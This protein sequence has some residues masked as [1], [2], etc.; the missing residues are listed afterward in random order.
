MAQ[1]S[2]I[3]TKINGEWKPALIDYTKVSNVWK[4]VNSVWTKIAGEWVNDLRDITFNVTEKK[5][6]EFTS[7]DYGVYILGTDDKLYTKDDWKNVYFDQFVMLRT[8]QTRAPSGEENAA[9]IYVPKDF[10]QSLVTSI[11]TDSYKGQTISFSNPVS[12]SEIWIEEYDGVIQQVISEKT[13]D[14]VSSYYVGSSSFYSANSF[15]NINGLISINPV[16]VAVVEPESQFIIAPKNSSKTLIWGGQDTLIS[17]VTTADVSTTA[18]LDYRGKENTTA[19]IQQLGSGNAPATDYCVSYVFENGQTGYLSALGQWQLVYD[20]KININDCMSL[21]GG[22]TIIESSY[23]ASTQVNVH[24]AWMKNCS[25][26]N[27]LNYGKNS[28]NWNVRAFADLEIYEDVPV[29]N[30]T[31]TLGNQTVTGD[32]P[33]TIPGR[34]QHTYEYSITSASGEATGN[35]PAL[36]DNYI[37]TTRLT[38]PPHL[39]Q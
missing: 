35:I 12:I 36:T 9:G 14:P 18:K 31:I 19:I 16:G 39:L 21:I 10:D 24:S 22:D 15:L 13:S 25:D 20:N 17:G 33:I 34:L 30:V 27:I 26:G 37:V 32:S 1:L 29:T 28:G 7:A 6:K 23:W 38:P 2:T 5:K 4:N 11:S 3:K 8:P